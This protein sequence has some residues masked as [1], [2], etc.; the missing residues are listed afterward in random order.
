MKNA[1][2]MLLRPMAFSERKT[3]V[4]E[5]QCNER[6][7]PSEH[8]GDGTCGGSVYSTEGAFWDTQF[9]DY[10]QV[11]TDEI[12]FFRRHRMHALFH[13]I[14]KHAWFSKEASTA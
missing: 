1:R 5:Q 13:L 12:S 7:P 8:G 9:R 3:S 4:P 11:S 10:P 2:D 6:M 14:R